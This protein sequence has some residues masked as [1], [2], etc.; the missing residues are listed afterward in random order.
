MFNH[1][2][3]KDED[4][5]LSKIFTC[6]PDIDHLYLETM[7]DKFPKS[8]I[9]FAKLRTLEFGIVRHPV[10]MNS[11]SELIRISCPN[12]KTLKIYWIGCL[13]MNMLENILTSAE[14]LEELFLG[15]YELSLDEVEVIRAKGKNLRKLTVY[16]CL[17]DTI[18]IIL[19]GLHGTKI[20]VTTWD[21][22]YETMDENCTYHRT[23]STCEFSL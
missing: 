15:N 18:K 11:I 13:G 21:R 22:E 3:Y 16:D 1:A 10:K 19:S 4:E 5:I 12:L 9:Q 17:S 2:V 23:G 8:P 20:Q 7:F 6:L 14:Y